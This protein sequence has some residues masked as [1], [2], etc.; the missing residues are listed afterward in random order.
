MWKS[1]G[2]KAG[3]IDKSELRVSDAGQDL[4]G[5]VIEIT[6][7]M[8]ME[9]SGEALERSGRTAPPPWPRARVT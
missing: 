6:E 8:I 7:D 1:L 3:R 9:L 5:D 4:S 2:A